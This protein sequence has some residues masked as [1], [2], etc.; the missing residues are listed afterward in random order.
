MNFT[1]KDKRYTFA[2]LII[3]S[4]IIT[5]CSEKKLGVNHEKVSINN[6][7]TSK[8][9][10]ESQNTPPGKEAT[11]LTEIAIK[12][13]RELDDQVADAPVPYFPYI[14]LQGNN[15]DAWGQEVKA[16]FEYVL[17]RYWTNQHVDKKFNQLASFRT[18]PIWTSD[19]M[20][21]AAIIPVFSDESRR[22][23][24]IDSGY[25]DNPVELTIF[26]EDSYYHDRGAFL[27]RLSPESE[28]GGGGPAPSEKTEKACSP[29]MKMNPTDLYPIPLENGYEADIEWAEDIYPY[30]NVMSLFS[31]SKDEYLNLYDIY[32]LSYNTDHSNLMNLTAHVYSRNSDVVRIWMEYNGQE[33]DL[34]KTNYINTERM[35]TPNWTLYD[36]ETT[37]NLFDSSENMASIFVELKSGE[38]KQLFNM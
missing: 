18:N 28:D 15:L 19:S 4:L 7:S 22:L 20:D 35:N 16:P 9:A 32:V 1:A 13:F 3:L 29:L 30:R 25:I 31:G 27:A 17:F 2:I 5:S 11:T 24:Y 12:C 10:T 38:I 36:V 8:V 37:S 21:I 26:D 23:F 34:G 33:I 6:N 14:S